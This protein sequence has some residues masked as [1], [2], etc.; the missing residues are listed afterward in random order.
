MSSQYPQVTIPHTEVHMLSSSSVDQEYQ[1]SVAL[2]FS[3]ADSDERYPV[4]YVLDANGCFGMV[5]E[6]VRTLQLG[7]Q[8]PELLIVGI[9]YPL[10]RFRDT[11][12]LR[13][14][15]MTPTENNQWLQERSKEL[16]LPLE[17]HGTGGAANFLRFICEE[18]QP[19]ID[20][21]FRS[22]TDD[23]NIAGDSFGGLFALYSLFHAANKFNRY[24][25]ERG[26][27]PDKE[28]SCSSNLSHACLTRFCLIL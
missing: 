11:F 1:I 23:Q 6:T 12:F 18:L 17:L 15:D 9:G 3:Y 21:N 10:T 5:T 27:C 8:C 22:N 25:K 24:I 13:A 7:E 16:Q 26:L 20:A 4:L 14:R 19:F 28:L 2:P